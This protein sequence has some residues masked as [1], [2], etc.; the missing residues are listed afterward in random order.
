MQQL[1][2]LRHG[3]AADAA[4]GQHDADRALTEEGQ[5]RAEAVARDLAGIL[6]SV[7]RLVTSDLL[8]AGQT[9]D[10]LAAAMPP[11]ARIV[12]PELS[13]DADPRVVFAWLQ[14]QPP[15]ATTVLVGHEPQMNLLLGLGLT[16]ALCGPALFKKAGFGLLRF[17]EGLDPGRG[18]LVLFSPPSIH[19][20]RRWRS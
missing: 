5:Q 8:R 16:G 6:G 7:D 11:G 19:L 9:A 17:S 12:L 1:L 10:V 3:I 18:K 14:R 2:L 13:P 4:P 20:Q 15:V